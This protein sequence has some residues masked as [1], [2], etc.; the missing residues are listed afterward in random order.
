MKRK[1]SNSKGFKKVNGKLVQYANQY[2]TQY[3]QYANQYPQYVNQYP[4]Q[5]SSCFRCCGPGWCGWCCPDDRGGGG[6]L[7]M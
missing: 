2:P 6:G 7:P 3:S 5:I 1:K 4:T